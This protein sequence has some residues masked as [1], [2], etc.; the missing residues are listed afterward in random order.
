MSLNDT[1]TSYSVEHENS[2]WPYNICNVIHVFTY[3]NCKNP[4]KFPTE[5]KRKYNNSIMKVFPFLKC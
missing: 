2:I 5:K 4:N 3:Q 1:I